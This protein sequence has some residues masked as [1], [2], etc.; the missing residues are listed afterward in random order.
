[1]ALLAIPLW[2]AALFGLFA[3]WQPTG[4]WLA[5]HRHEMVFGFVVAII[6]G[7][8]L[9][10]VQT[11]TGRVGLSGKPLMA[12]TAVWLA[13]RL[14]WLLGLPPLW[15]LPLELAFLPA[16]AVLMA[17]S[18][19]A[20]KQS[21]N[22][23]V[24]L[25][26]SLLAAADAVVMA[27]LVTANED[28]QR[29]GVLAALWLIIALIGLI[30]GRVIP[31]FTQRGLRKPTA[32]VPW[33][34]LDNSL[35]GGT[36][37]IAV[38]YAMGLGNTPQLGLAVLLMV[39]ATGHGVRWLRWHDVGLWRVPLL[40]SLYLAYLWLIIGILGVALWHLGVLTNIS[41]AF[42]ALTMG[43]V[44]GMILAMIARVTLGH[45]GRP[46]QEPAAMSLAFALFHV[47]VAVRVFGVFEWPIVALCVAAS[48]WALAFALYLWYYA[49][50][51]SQP[52]IDGNMG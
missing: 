51:L 3:D 45:T 44:S 13:A 50:M 29:R 23:P 20:V 24:V 21:R 27:G 34:W 18:L 4:G 38:C 11:W 35:L 10:A 26:L 40:W 30:G 12:L 6:A 42:H 14:G 36:L 52:R 17:Q 43:A 7:F 41:P 2:L 46:L 5:W 37:L 19:W 15:L 39:V 9:T 16:V 47:G 31:F 28:W 33:P 22:Y 1:L 48:C 8:L 25:V 49:P 32:I